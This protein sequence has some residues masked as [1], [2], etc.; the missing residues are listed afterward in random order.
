M[1]AILVIDLDAD[2]LPVGS[3]ASVSVFGKYSDEQEDDFLAYKRNIPVRPM[4][5]K[6]SS[7]A[8]ELRE[9]WSG[10]AYSEGWNDCID[11]IEKCG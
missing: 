7:K 3:Y 4:P 11:E 8:R 9:D 1:K 2:S 5:Q 6:E 10:L